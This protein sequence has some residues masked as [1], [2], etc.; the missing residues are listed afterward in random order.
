MLQRFETADGLVGYRSPELARLGV[1]H[2]FTTRAL[3]V[4]PFDPELLARLRRLADA[5][6]DAR[7]VD[8]R[9][10]HGADVCDAA[11]ITGRYEAEAD[12]LVTDDPAHLLLIR[13]ADCVPILLAR[14]D[15]LR[16]AAAHAGWRGLV[17][18]VI[19]NALERL[20]VGEYVAAVGPCA[21]EANYEVGPEV[22]TAFERA[23]LAAA[24]VPRTNAR[25]HIDLRAAATLQLERAGVTRIDTTDRCTYEHRAEFWSYR[26]VVTHAGL[27]RT[28]RLAAVIG[29][30]PRPRETA[31]TAV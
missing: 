17:A 29:C 27:P 11:E 25:P 31:R 22:V 26:R 9:Q 3:D 15:G 23:G 8:L 20:G 16:I 10:V 6:P 5:P 28:G 2:A 19:P 12:A 30:A 7:V 1:P 14:A 4:G 24:V 21:S 18:G 13:T